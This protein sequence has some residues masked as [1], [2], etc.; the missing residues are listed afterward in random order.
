MLTGMNPLDYWIS[1]NNQIRLFMNEYEE[2]GYKYF[3]KNTSEQLKRDM[4]HLYTSGN[5]LEKTMV[6]PVLAAVKL[7]F[8]KFI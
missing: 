7:Y 8:G 5:A 4:R 1:K 6:L 3:P 2:N